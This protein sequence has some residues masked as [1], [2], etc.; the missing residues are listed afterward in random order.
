MATTD[1]ELVLRTL[2]TVMHLGNCTEDLTLIRR[3]LAL[4][5]AC[6]DYLR[7]QQVRI[8]YAEEQDLYVFIDSTKSDELR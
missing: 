8:I 7:Q 6:F 4:Y 3:S 1:P 2:N 5:E